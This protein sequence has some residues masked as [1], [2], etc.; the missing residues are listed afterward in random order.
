MDRII[1]FQNGNKTIYWNKQRKGFW[2]EDLDCPNYDCE[3]AM[4]RPGNWDLN[5]DEV[6]AIYDFIGGLL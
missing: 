5:E 4:Y 3:V 1:I 2:Y 6:K